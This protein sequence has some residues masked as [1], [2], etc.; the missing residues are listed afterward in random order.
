MEPQKTSNVL[1]IAVIFGFALIALAIFFSGVGKKTVPL[2][3]ENNSAIEGRGQIANGKIRPVDQTDYIRG[4]PNAPIRIVEYSDYD[5]P[6]CKRFHSVMQQI[7]AEYG[8]SGR[9]AWVFR[10]FPVQNTHPNAPY[11]AKAAL[12]VGDLAGNQAF[13]QFSDRVFDSREETAFTNISQLGNLATD[14][15]ANDAAFKTCLNSDKF[16]K[17]IQDSIAD[18]TKAGVD[19]TPYSFILVGDQQVSI[20]GSESYPMV[21]SLIDNIIDQISGDAVDTNVPPAASTIKIS[22]NASTTEE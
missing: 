17:A 21:K 22:P 1:P 14:A 6:Y 12:C 15:G 9:V 20:R 16:D 18:G 19:A 4:N 3:S 2:T 10:Q 8:A 11:I 5:C 13:W 7:M